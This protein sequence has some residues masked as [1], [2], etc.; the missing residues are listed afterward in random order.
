MFKQQRRE[1]FLQQENNGLRFEKERTIINDAY[2][3]Y[4]YYLLKRRY[5]SFQNIIIHLLST[6][7]SWTLWNVTTK[8]KPPKYN[9]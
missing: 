8:I 3:I 7:S 5:L 2:T 4:R 9:D 6:R 1:I